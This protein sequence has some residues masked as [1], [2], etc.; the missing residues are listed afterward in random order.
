MA[1]AT[2]SFLRQVARS[3]AGRVLEAIADAEAAVDA[4]RYGWQ[5][6][7]PAAVGARAEGLIERYELDAARAVVEELDAEEWEPNNSWVLFLRARGRVSM[8]SGDPGS[9]LRDFLEWGERWPTRNPAAQCH[10]RGHAAL[11]HAKLGN[12]REAV[13]LAEEELELSRAFGAARAVGV[14]QHALGLVSRGSAALALLRESVATLETSQARI[15][16][17][18]ARI[19]LG[20]ALRRAGEGAEA[21]DL[22]HS[23]LALAQDLGAVALAH[24]AQ[25]ELKLA[26]GRPRRRAASG[27]DSLTPGELRVVELAAEGRTNREIAEALFVTVKAVEWHLRNAYPKLRVQG[28][29]DLPAVLREARS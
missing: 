8:A 4:R 11:A 7:Y 29:K 28:K 27:I 17:C 24:R 1:Y 18:R 5:Q 20:S 9:A 3:Q 26:G 19:H 13:R 23:G 25:E 12:R 15:E 6:F 10:W 14:S 2:A 21:R 22:L 16:V